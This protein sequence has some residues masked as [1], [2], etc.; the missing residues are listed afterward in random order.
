MIYPRVS[1]DGQTIESQIAMMVPF[2]QRRGWDLVRPATTYQD[3]GIS[4]AD[5]HLQQRVGLLQLLADAERGLFDLVAVVGID[6]FSRADDLIERY[7]VLGMLQRHGI[8]IADAHTGS[9]YDLNTEDGALYVGLGAHFAARDRR[10]IV[11]QMERGRRYAIAENRKPAGVDPYGYAHDATT[12]RLVERADEAIVVRQIFERVVAGWTC[13]RI[14]WDLNDRCVPLRARRNQAQAWTRPRVYQIVRAPLYL[15]QYIVKRA[16]DLAIVVP[17]IIDDETWHAARQALS[18]RRSTPQ[19]RSATRPT[20][21]ALAQGISRCARCGASMWLTRTQKRGRVI[22]YYYACVARLRPTRPE[23]RCPA[24]YRRV[25]DVD[26]TLWHLIR[27]LMIAGWRTLA[28]EIR[29]A[30]ACDPDDE[31]QAIERL[32]QQLAR[33][34]RA[35]STALGHHRRGTIETSVL[36]RELKTIKSE[37]D[38]TRAMLARLQQHTRTQWTPQDLEIT[39]EHIRARLERCTPAE[40][41]EVVL[42]FIPGRGRRVVTIGDESVSAVACLDPSH[43]DLLG[44]RFSTE[45]RTQHMSLPPLEIAL[46][47]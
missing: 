4:A 23:Q 37:M 7:A 45:N 41:R 16:E 25:A 46:A 27:D 6:R 3:D 40:Q 13:A 36:N 20:I 10:K 32:Q 24:R 5:G 22:A 44:V 2:V 43:L 19:T 15:G 12:G 14:A 21:V 35:Q 39:F 38:E 11:E 33:L 17:Q 28:E 31:T 18:A 34:E 47:A 8:L 30:G 1:G 9:V 29:A 26:A 42:L